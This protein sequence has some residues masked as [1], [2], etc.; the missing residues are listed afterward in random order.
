ML[1]SCT[2]FEGCLSSPTP[3]KYPL[4]HFPLGTSVW[5]MAT[6]KEMSKLEGHSD[7]KERGHQPGRQDHRVGL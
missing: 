7:C 6:G 2:I 4:T 5:D 1:L 3:V